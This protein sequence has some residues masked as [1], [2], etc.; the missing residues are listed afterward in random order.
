MPPTPRT[1]LGLAL[2]EQLALLNQLQRMTP[3]ARVVLGLDMAPRAYMRDPAELIDPAGPATRAAVLQDAFDAAR[4][5]D[6]NITVE[7][8][9]A[10]AEPGTRAYRTITEMLGPASATLLRTTDTTEFVDA[11][12]DAF[13]VFRTIG[14]PFDGGISYGSWRYRQ[15]MHVRLPDEPHELIGTPMN[16]PMGP[17]LHYPPYGGK[18]TTRGHRTVAAVMWSQAFDREIPL[19]LRGPDLFRELQVRSIEHD[20]LIGWDY[21]P[22]F[23][24]SHVQVA[25]MMSTGWSPIYRFKV[26]E[27]TPS[28]RTIEQAR[29]ELA[30]RL[31]DERILT[32]DVA[33]LQRIRGQHR[34]NSTRRT[35]TP[36]DVVRR[37]DRD[38]YYRLSRD[39]LFDMALGRPSFD[40]TYRPYEWE[41]MRPERFTKAL[42]KWV[43]WLFARSPNEVYWNS[44]ICML[45]GFSEPSN[46]QLVSPFDHGRTD[47]Y[48]GR[49]F[50]GRTRLHRHGIREREHP[51]GRPIPTLDE[52]AAYDAARHAEAFPGRKAAPLQAFPLTD[53]ER[54][55]EALVAYDQRPLAELVSALQ[56]DEWQQA[57]N[58]IPDAAIRAQWN[59][60]VR[61]LNG[62]V[63]GYGMPAALRLPFI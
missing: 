40:V 37:F 36:G 62:Q 21:D 1:N 54:A 55:D 57:V 13:A 2:P 25:H 24:F 29:W 50:A 22:D 51:T 27:G 43:R 42:Q 39:D 32:A 41:H 28:E 60:L 53:A 46:L 4:R 33:T 6:P 30:A 26:V 7:E 61:R 15:G 34:P 56:E 31:E 18:V 35:R 49:M 20:E 59:D 38:P 3:P 47:A 52:A 9:L 23:L 16:A 48:A 63:D 17:D 14:T 45:T 5:D 10:T 44:R 11:L 12:R 19:D 8:F 58:A